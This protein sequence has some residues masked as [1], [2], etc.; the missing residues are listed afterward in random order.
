[1]T[2]S[3]IYSPAPVQEANMVVRVNGIVRPHQTAN[4]GADSSGGLPDQVVS[5]GTGMRSRTGAI[6]WAGDPLAQAPPH[7]LRRVDGWPPREGDKVE[8]TATV[9][10]VPF[11]R[12]TGRIGATTGSL[13]D[14]TL[15]SEITDVLNDHLSRAVNIPPELITAV[16]MSYRTAWRAVEQAGLGLLPQPTG[17]GDVIIHHAPQGDV[18]PIIGGDSYIEGATRIDDPYGLTAWTGMV[19]NAL[20]GPTR[21]G[22][23]VLCVARTAPSVTSRLDVHFSDDQVYSLRRN[24]D[25][26]L[27]LHV[28]SVVI[29][30][31]AWTGEGVP[32]LAMR[33]AF[34]FAEVFTSRTT[35][36][37]RAVD[38]VNVGVSRI[39]GVGV[40][41]AQLRYGLPATLFDMVADTPAWPTAVHVGNIPQVRTRAARGFENVP[42]KN[43]IDSW[44]DATLGSMWMDEFGKP[45]LYARSK[46]LSTAVARTVRVNEK[47]FSGS[48]SV[49]AD[50]VF[51]RVVVEGEQAAVQGWY[52]PQSSQPDHAYRTPAFQDPM[53]RS[54]TEDGV[55]E[56]FVEAAAEVDWGPLDPSASRGGGVDT[57]NEGI[58]SWFGGVVIRADGVDNWVQSPEA[59]ASNYQ[60]TTERLGHRAI[61]LTETLTGLPANGTFYPRFTT[62]PTNTQLPYRGQ[63]LP[64]IRA[65]W[66]STW[67]PFTRSSAQGPAYAPTLQH[68][69]SW[70]L[71]PADAQRLATALAAEVA[72][73]VPTFSSV[74]TLWDPRRQIGDIEKWI[75]VD[76]DGNDSWEALVLV[77]GYNEDWD[78]DVPSQSVTTRT[79]SLTDPV[80]GKTYFDL[81][82]A[83]DDY[84]DVAGSTTTYQQL[85][86]ALPGAI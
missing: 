66:V 44:G 17:E 75:G 45:H 12:F 6:R 53:V 2:Q 26:T 77:N 84:T 71:A 81:T 9:G 68:D 85:Y 27:A 56:R 60:L 69:A 4:W 67:A 76:A 25:N 43:V 19:T 20:V 64:I 47:V 79:I 31:G 74:A 58:G 59:G 63:S 70:W 61:K 10:G 72:Q 21:A 23:S 28:N 34:G 5:A 55:E 36:I 73:P 49:G 32:I 83:Y 22:R 33:I 82:A 30:E 39:T 7:P 57:G 40:A 8:I 14:G 52:S 62:G 16:G 46:L 37:T 35:T 42:A 24:T 54:M 41:A 48:W 1:M 11:R 51:G 13:V 15:T 18:Y 3:G 80:E 65:M 29:W 78:G 86:N 38:V 50:S